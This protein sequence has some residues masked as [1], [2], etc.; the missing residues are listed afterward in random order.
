MCLIIS[1][2]A[3]LFAFSGDIYASIPILNVL[4]IN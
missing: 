4:N 1:L 3:S 2:D